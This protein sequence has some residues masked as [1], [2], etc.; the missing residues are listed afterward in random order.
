MDTAIEGYRQEVSS[1]EGGAHLPDGLKERF[2]KKGLRLARDQE[3]SQQANKVLSHIRLVNR[4][5]GTISHEILAA[6][7]DLQYWSNPDA[8]P[9]SKEDGAQALA[10]FLWRVGHEEF[11]KTRLCLSTGLLKIAPLLESAASSRSTP[12]NTPAEFIWPIIEALQQGDPDSSRSVNRQTQAG[13]ID[14]PAFG[15]PAHFGQPV[16]GDWLPGSA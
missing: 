2:R 1:E 11:R 4:P 14:I 13:K 15:T 8:R 9:G 10:K 3:H 5:D 6:A 7:V 16:F 12:G